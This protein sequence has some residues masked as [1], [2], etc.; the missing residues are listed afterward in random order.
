[1]RQRVSMFCCQISSGRSPNAR[2]STVAVAE[3]STV[4]CAGRVG[5]ERGDERRVVRRVAGQLREP[6]GP[7]PRER[8]R[9]ARAAVRVAGV[10]L[11]VVGGEP[12]DVGGAFARCPVPKS[13]IAGHV[14][15]PPEPPA[16]LLAPATPP[17]TR[18]PL[19]P[20]RRVRRSPP[21]PYQRR[22]WCPLCRRCRPSR[23]LP[24][25]RCQRRPQRLSCPRC[26]PNPSNR[27]RRWCRPRRWSR[28]RRLPRLSPSPQ[29]RS[30]RPRRWFPRAPAG[31]G[32]TGGVAAVRT[33]T[34]GHQRDQ[35]RDETRREE[36]RTDQ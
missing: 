25:R 17:T 4:F 29:R 35:E 31:A 36:E 30:T 9:V 16:P 19:R 32:G 23:R 26:R 28:L 2:E 10:A 8:Q 18:P 15:A 12:A 34:R 1:M 3:L 7:E 27:P 20:C 13:A 33:A 6:E 14:V 5:L 11:E 22:R 24:Y 21:L